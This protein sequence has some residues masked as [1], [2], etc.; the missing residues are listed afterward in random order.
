MMAGEKGM[1]YNPQ[2]LRWEGNENTLQAFDTTALETPTPQLRPRS[3]YIEL[4]HHRSNTSPSRPALISHVPTGSG[5]NIQVQNGM[6]YDPQQMKWLKVKGGRD[7]SSQMSPSVTDVEDD[8]DAFAGIEDLKDENAPADALVD[9][10]SSAA[11]PAENF[12]EEFDIGLRFID[13]QRN[14]EDAWRQKCS[15]WFIGDQPRPDDGR[16]R[17]NI[18]A[19]VPADVL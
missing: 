1:I 17:Y 19:I 18:R 14:E 6:V 3:S 15:A 5:F 10:M 8:E 12:H 9:G 13:L 2:T 4:T 11:A 16:W 7:V